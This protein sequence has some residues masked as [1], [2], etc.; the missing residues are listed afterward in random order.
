MAFV[1]GT[2][3][4]DTLD[5]GDGADTLLGLFGADVLVG[6]GGDDL[7]LGGFGADTL[8]GGAGNDVL[9]GGRGADTAVFQGS[10]FDYQLV[11]TPALPGFA[12]VRDRNADD[13]DDGI[14]LLFGVEAMAFGDATVFLD[15]RNNGPLVR[16]ETFT[17]EAGDTL[18]LDGAALLANDLDVDGDAL[19]LL[20]VRAG[21]GGT[22]VL[23]GG[24]VTFAPDPGFV[25]EA[26]F[27]Y[28]VGDGRGG[29]A[30]AAATVI[31]EDTTAPLVDADLVF[32]TGENRAVGAL[33]GTATASDAVGVVSWAITGGDPDGF[34][35]I[36]AASGAITLTA[37]GAAA[38]ANDFETGPNDFI[39]SV[40]ATDAAGNTG[41]G[42]VSVAVTN[43][44]EAPVVDAAASLLDGSVTELPAGAPGEGSATLAASGVIAFA[45]VDVADTHVATAVPEGSGYRG[46]FVLAQPAQTG[47]TT[48][49]AVGWTFAVEDAALADLAA[50]ETLVEAYAVTVA[51]QGG[52]L[53]TATVTVTITGAN[54]VPTILASA[55]AP[56]V[57]AAE[58]SAQPLAAAGTLTVGDADRGDTLDV[59]FRF[60]DDLSWS[61]GTL[62]P[63]LAD[64]LVA[65][66]E[67]GATA[68]AP[69]TVG[70]TF[71][72]DPLAL[73]GLG[74]GES[75]TWSYT[76][77]ATDRAGATASETVR[78]TLTGTNDAPAG[79]DDA[80]AL[81]N[82]GP[83]P[84]TRVTGDLLANDGDPDATDVL[85]VTA[86][87]LGDGTT[88]PVTATAPA[89]V[90]LAFG[91]LT[92]AADGSFAY[93]FD[94]T[95]AGP[96]PGVLEAAEA[97]SYTLGDGTLEA[98]ASVT[99]DLAFVPET[100][101]LTV[102]TE[103]DRV[104]PFDGEVSLRE[105]IAYA[106]QL[107]APGDP[108]VIAFAPDVETILLGDEDG[109][110]TV[111]PAAGEAARALLVDALAAPLVIDG[112]VDG[113]GKPLVAVDGNGAARVLDVRDTDVQLS[114][115]ALANGSA[116][117]S[118]DPADADGGVLRV[119]GGDATLETVSLANGE[120]ARGG[121]L[122]LGDG[123]H[124]LRNVHVASSSASEAGGGIWAGEGASL[125]LVDA[126]VTDNAAGSASAA[127]AMGG[128]VAVFLTDG[129]TLAVTGGRIAGNTAT[130]AGE[131][132]GGGLAVSAPRSVIPLSAATMDGAIVEDNV[133]E[134]AE[135]KGG[136][137][138]AL[139]SPGF[140]AADSLFARNAV[141]ADGAG[142]G[143]GLFTETGGGL[144]RTEFTGNTVDAGASGH[145]GGLKVAPA[146]LSGE[147]NGLGFSV[148][149]LTF[150]SNAVRAADAFG[151]GFAYDGIVL[152]LP[153]GIVA[154]GNS[155]VGDDGAGGGTAAGGG[156]YI[157]GGGD[158]SDQRLG[159]TIVFEDN[160]AEGGATARGGGVFFSDYAASLDG[161]TASGNSAIAGLVAEGGGMYLEDGPV[162]AFVD[163]SF[164]D[165]TVAAQTVRGGGLFAEA[166]VPFFLTTSTVSG[167]VADGEAGAAGAGAF[168]V[169]PVFERVTIDR[170]TAD[171]G[172]ASVDG[173]GAFLSEASLKN[174]TI[175]GNVTQSGGVAGLLLDRGVVSLTTVTDNRGGVGIDGLG[176]MRMSIVAGNTRETGSDLGRTN[177]VIGVGVDPDPNDLIRVA[178]SLD[179][180]FVLEDGRPL[181]ADNGGPVETV[182]LAPT[183]DNPAIDRLDTPQETDARGFPTR[184]LVNPKRTKDA[185]SYELQSLS[186]DPSALTRPPD[187]PFV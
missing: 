105:A 170:N 163:A 36:D 48:D 81:G 134:G 58:A 176:S 155:A 112:R 9:L 23:S 47:S 143:G 179:V 83:A 57:E 104:D 59:A 53:D 32:S 111:D 116:L 92:V 185:G 139:G 110:G 10:I 131:T 41:T 45:D 177:S 6:G 28:V 61:G 136:G 114:G 89:D 165:N 88:V 2:F 38:A 29:T 94:G 87:T 115:L 75:V 24:S 8:R 107:G 15:G 43:V 95:A 162:A 153:V 175:V 121:A 148:T 102:T 21:T 118:G 77:S 56:F 135:A 149:D 42:T 145:G 97:F 49:R 146:P 68:T 27:A 67:T 60:N 100:A 62:D 130:S 144:A 174:G 65:G 66:F 173:A 98:T 54:D 106:A 109:D 124:V 76:V 86:I 13:G 3:S 133:A 84:A 82:T 31:V 129:D 30:L 39:L 140:S 78:F 183:P 34:F 90:D 99:V 122:W 69:G 46:T 154:S 12:L 147:D 91:R 11:L 164:T 152:T 79:A 74:A 25:G 37:A 169:D 180:L 93:A 187:E 108:D 132:A 44:N 128:G 14:D 125:D 16:G 64:A 151:G 120:A 181:L 166:D 72:T 138:A 161:V 17:L 80:F 186:P 126:T 178:P 119:A 26:S 182:A 71:A 35:A 168:A 117:A 1:I 33:V 158:F 70:W 19:T 137:V 123:D 18:A 63:A 171:G 85:S 172:S 55:P 96:A 50:G 101:G 22:P 40:A 184:A 156:A 150:T 51:D 142:A 127:A 113:D 167:N 4:N 7:L 103:A 141:V 159:T 73:D 5:G 157:A 52:A 160:R 20:G